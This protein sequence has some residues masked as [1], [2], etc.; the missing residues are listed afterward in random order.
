MPSTALQEKLIF[1]TVF[2]PLSKIQ[3]H[4][5]MLGVTPLLC[6]GIHF[7]PLVGVISGVHLM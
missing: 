3:L 4:R 5:K 7:V 6:D 1:K 2:G